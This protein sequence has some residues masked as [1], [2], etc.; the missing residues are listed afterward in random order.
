MKKKI[1]IISLFVFLFSSNFI[2]VEAIP[3]PTT[4]FYVND[5][6]NILNKET[7]EYII[8]QS[9]NLDQKT[10]AQIVVVTVENLEGKDI[11][12]YAT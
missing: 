5:Y 4:Q 1:F 9:A 2:N 6:A 8:N 10:K 12:T 7:E 11:E 3:S